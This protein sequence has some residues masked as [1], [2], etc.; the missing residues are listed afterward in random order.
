MIYAQSPLAIALFCGFVLVVLGLSFY[1]GRR[2]T[3]SAG[4]Y[5]AGG[6]VHWFTNGIAF[7]GDY[8]SAASFLGICGMIAT[9]GFDGWMYAVG[10]LAGWM[11]A[12]FLV[13]E[14]MKRLGKFTFTDALDA[15]FNSKGI[16]LMAAI[17]TL[18][19][20]VFYLIPQMVGAGTL[21]TPLLGL[22]HA[23]GV[24]IVGVVVTI[25]VAT[26]GMASTT[27]VQFLKGGLL[28]IFSTILVVAVLVRGLS[29]TPDQ[30]GTKTY[31]DFQTLQ[32][33]VAADGSLELADGA[34]TVAA[35]WQSSPLAE[36]GFVKLTYN[37]EERIWHLKQDGE[38]S[39]LLEET[40]YVA[41][42]PDGTRS[43]N[44]GSAEEGKFF[45]VGH[46]KE[47]NLNGETVLQTGALGPLAFLSTMQKSTIV[48]WGTK[49][50]K[51]GDTL[52]TIY[53]QKPTPGS[54]VLRPGLKFKVEGAT[55]AEKFNFVSLM[56]ALFCG[57]AALPHILIRYY[58]VPSQA[59]A[60]KSTLV[61][62]A[63]IGFFYILTLFLGLGA[64]TNG[65]V[66]IMDNNMS[67]PLLA[68]SFGVILFAVIS[69]IAFATVLGTV[70]GLIVAAS[71]AVAHDLMDNFLGMRMSDHGKV[72]AGKLAAV[73]V[74]AIAIYLGIV[75]EGMNVSFLVGWA[76]ALAASANLPAILMLLFW[77]KTT[78]HG[79]TASILVGLTS[80]MG[81]ILISPDM[82][83]RY[84]L[85]P[86]QAPISFNSPAAISIP[87]S[88][89]ALVVVS[90]LT[91]RV[92]VSEDAVESAR[93]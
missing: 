73:V 29:T 76:F 25:I 49:I 21:V 9:A 83:V 86:S 54:M 70:S 71:G 26:A 23:A 28:L 46:M 58:T 47:I 62:I 77:K 78:A 48:L 85:L 59:A 93:A 51:E 2:T 5:A 13:A 27:M 82:Y 50:V 35:N 18:V 3:S 20:S 75:F 30:G 34:Y 66:N 14:P 89:I 6:N 12:L 11:V 43:Y 24:V 19:V 79:V 15:K 36:A 57:T 80:A 10:Y 72:L 8:L 87:L 22:P 42:L 52:L 33:T 81:L 41:Q 31:H 63:A 60:R 53:Y 90:L 65:V 44:G 16:Q 1:L 67:A 92:E 84:G 88:F 91:K 38:A 32:A 61:A 68:L 4:Y 74:G 45:P 7:A 56:L 55:A 37:G 40:L 64:M 39:Y 69:S 17:S